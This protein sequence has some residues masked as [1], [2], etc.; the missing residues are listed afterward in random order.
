MEE[1]RPAGRRLR[2]TMEARTRPQRPLNPAVL[3]ALIARHGRRR[4]A[5][6]LLRALLAP[7]PRVRRLHEQDL[8]PRLG[9]DIGIEPPPVR[10]HHWEL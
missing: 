9:R 5:W 3:Q 7:R 4:V 10:R 8:S 2:E 6:A 1:P